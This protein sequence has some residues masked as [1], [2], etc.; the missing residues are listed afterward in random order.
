MS[1]EEIVEA[2]KIKQVISFDP[3][4]SKIVGDPGFAIQAQASSGLP[5]RF[6]SSDTSVARVVGDT[7]Y[8]TGVGTTDIIAHQDGDNLYSTAEPVAQNFTVVPLNLKVWHK[9]GDNGKTANNSIKSHLQIENN[10][11]IGVAYSEITVRY[12]FTAENYAGI[13]TWIDFAQLGNDKVSMKYVSLPEPHEGAFG[14][15]EYG[16]D[17]SLGDLLPG[18]GSG[19]IESRFANTDWSNFD[20]TGDYSFLSNSSYVENKKITL[21][22]NGQLVWGTEPVQ[23]NRNLSLKVYSENENANT[24]TNTIRTYLKLAN[25]GNVPVNYKDLS[26]RYWFTKDSEADLTYWIDYAKLGKSHL[27]GQFGTPGTS[28]N[29]ADT[30][31]ELSVDSTAGT[32]YPLSST[33]EVHLRISKSDWSRFN[34]SDDH[35]WLSRAP[36]AE[37]EHI[38]VYYKGE[39]VYGIEPGTGNL[40]IGLNQSMS[41][42]KNQLQFSEFSVY[43][44][45]VANKLTIQLNS[46]NTEDVQITL[47]SCLGTLLL[48]KKVSGNRHELDLSA[49]PQGVYIITVTSSGTSVIRKIV[50]N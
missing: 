28:V 46:K 49:I 20:E 10:D 38:T 21:Y 30:Y 8:I 13:N 33:G 50:K 25:E 14:Y 23:V 45:P 34:E 1:A 22:R 9:D 24:G 42:G 4:V 40:R 19:P 44:N 2:M 27:S 17:A 18:G 29:G 35:S 39:L 11:T 43:P 47:H 31:F 6:T 12:W 5:V 26:I 3:L 36:L 15:I 41:G 48:A 16:F 37:N 32:L 7:I